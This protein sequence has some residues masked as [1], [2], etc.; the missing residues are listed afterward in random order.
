MEGVTRPVDDRL[1]QL[2]PGPRRRRQ[3]GDDMDESEL[4][5]LLALPA[6]APGAPASTV[7]WPAMSLSHGRCLLDH[8]HHLTRVGREGGVEGCGA[9]TRWLRYRAPRTPRAVA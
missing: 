4:V 5:E 3:P 9:V 1:Q 6:C 8:T 2:V 7:R